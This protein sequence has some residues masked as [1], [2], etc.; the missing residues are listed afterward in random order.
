MVPR[1]VQYFRTS[2]RTPKH[3]ITAHTSNPSRRSLIR[4]LRTTCWEIK[5][6]VVASKK[7]GFFHYAT[8][9]TEAALRNVEHLSFGLRSTASKPVSRKL[10]NPTKPRGRNLMKKMHVACGKCGSLPQ[11]FCTTLRKK[12][13]I[14]IQSTNNRINSQFVLR[15]T[16]F[17]LIKISTYL[18]KN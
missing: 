6:A 3:C 11:S 14:V 9:W 7:N 16:T 18:Y 5:K 12:P 8:T 4:T 2:H 17:Q 13:W 10:K 15:W 1:G